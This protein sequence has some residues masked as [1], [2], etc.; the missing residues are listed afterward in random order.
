MESAD[1]D[2]SSRIF[3]KYDRIDD[4]LNSN[5]RAIVQCYLKLALRSRLSLEMGGGDLSSSLSDES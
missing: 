2:K 3:L 4:V 1:E 5:T